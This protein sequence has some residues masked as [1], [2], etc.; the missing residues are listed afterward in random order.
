MCDFNNTK[1][2]ISRTAYLIKLHCVII[3]FRLYDI[4]DSL[5]F[6]NFFLYLWSFH[7]ASLWYHPSMFTHRSDSYIWLY[8]IANLQSGIRRSATVSSDSPRSGSY[9][10]SYPTCLYPVCLLNCYKIATVKSHLIKLVHQLNYFSGIAFW[11]TFEYGTHI[12]RQYSLIPFL[13]HTEK[14]FQ[15]NYPVLYKSARSQLPQAL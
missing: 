8:T 11:C 13:L 5:S 10:W 1:C 4:K 2:Y 14:Q 7:P 12:L 15:M 6:F 9:Y 3:G